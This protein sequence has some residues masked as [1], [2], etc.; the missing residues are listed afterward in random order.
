MKRALIAALLAAAALAAIAP[1]AGAVGLF[2]IYWDIEDADQNGYGGGLKD[3]RVLTEALSLDG[4]VSYVDFEDSDLSVVP[5]E[6]TLV[7]DLG[8]VYLGIGSGYYIFNG[9]GAPDDH[10]GWYY[11]AGVEFPLSKVVIF[12]EVRWLKLNARIDQ[13]EAG[14][15]GSVDLD[16]RT[17]HAGISLNLSR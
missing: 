11:L 2:G 17:Y 13:P 7:G 1:R 6:T 3:T 9:G 14:A 16:S 5:L 4:R 15:P 8:L 10:F 12:G